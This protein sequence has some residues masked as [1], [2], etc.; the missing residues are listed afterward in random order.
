MEFCLFK[1]SSNKYW[2]AWSTDT[3]VAYILTGTPNEM[4]RQM[5]KKKKQHKQEQQE[6]SVWIE[7]EEKGEGEEKQ[8]QQEE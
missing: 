7:Q 1:N 6:Q 3:D 5:E 4:S 2:S 8:H